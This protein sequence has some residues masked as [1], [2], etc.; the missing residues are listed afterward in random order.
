MTIIAVLFTLL[1]GTTLQSSPDLPSGYVHLCLSRCG[2]VAVQPRL[3]IFSLRFD[4]AFFDSIAE[5]PVLFVSYFVYY[6]LS[7]AVDAS[8]AITRFLQYCDGAVW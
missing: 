6:G 1:T 4:Y 5:L 8:G 3:S 2:D 7:F